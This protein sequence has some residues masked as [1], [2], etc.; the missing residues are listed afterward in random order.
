MA[1][2]PKIAP[3]DYFPAAL[4]CCSH[5][6]KTVKNI[7]DKLTDT[8]LGMFRQTCFG[9]FLD[10][11]LMFNGQLIHY[12]LLREVNEPRIDVISF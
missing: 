6:G 4:T 1:L 8:Q 11:S 10:T 2:V 7:K 5:L 9:H 12:F 3:A